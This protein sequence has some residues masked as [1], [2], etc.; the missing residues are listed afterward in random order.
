MTHAGRIHRPA[1]VAARVEPWK[2]DANAPITPQMSAIRRALCL[3]KPLR[4]TIANSAPPIAQTLI[5]RQNVL[6]CHGI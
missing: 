5:S 1:P 3:E 2:L 4:R 6:G